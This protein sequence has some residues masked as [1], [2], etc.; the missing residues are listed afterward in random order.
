MTE[1]PLKIVV[2]KKPKRTFLV[3][4][5]VIC[6]LSE[7]FA[8]AC[9][10]EW[11]KGKNNTITLDE[12]D[13]K[14]F[15]IFVTWILTKGLDAADLD[16][17]MLPDDPS[18]DETKALSILKSRIKQ[19]IP[20]ISLA[21]QLICPDFHNAVIDEILRLGNIGVKEYNVAILTN[22]RCIKLVYEHAQ[23]GSKLRQLL[24]DFAFTLSQ[25]GVNDIVKPGYTIPEFVGDFLSATYRRLKNPQKTISVQLPPSL[26]TCMYH[27]HPDQEK[28]YKCT[29][30]DPNNAK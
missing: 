10:E 23:A 30:Q 20:G 25:N 28:A 14:V 9:K 24:L 18:Y 2:G 6:S 4:K 19:L 29:D 16:E 22:Q 11:L 26:P 13:P 5:I 17:L 21:D 1:P 7:F 12:E 27:I 15:A 3:N 8:T